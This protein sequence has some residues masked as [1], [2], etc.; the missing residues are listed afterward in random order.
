MQKSTFQMNLL[1]IQVFVTSNTGQVGNT[2]SVKYADAPV[3]GTCFSLYEMSSSYLLIPSLIFKH[4]KDV[5]LKEAG[6]RLPKF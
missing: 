5:K 6:T 4:Q 3:A 1:P 2:G